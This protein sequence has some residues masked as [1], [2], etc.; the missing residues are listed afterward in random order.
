MD[1]GDLSSDLLKLIPWVETGNIWG[2][3]RSRKLDLS[4]PALE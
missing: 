3:S 1:S 2:A 4:I